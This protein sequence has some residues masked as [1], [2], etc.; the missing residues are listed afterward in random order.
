MMPNSK[1][2]DSSNANLALAMLRSVRTLE[3]SLP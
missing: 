2:T 3:V 1:P